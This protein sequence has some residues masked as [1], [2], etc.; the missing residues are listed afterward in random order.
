MEK[1]SES[2]RLLIVLEIGDPDT[3]VSIAKA[4][5]PEAYSQADVKRGKV[6]VLC[7]GGSVTIE[8]EARDAGSLRALLNAYAYLLESLRKLVTSDV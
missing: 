4:L 2:L 5:T 3:A 7:R 6:T 8:I 1:P